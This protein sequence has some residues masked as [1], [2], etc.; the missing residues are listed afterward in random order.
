MGPQSALRRF[1]GDESG[2]GI[3]FA[4]ATLLVLVGFL[5]FV[6]N[7]GRLLDRRT[8]M[9]IAADA[10][11]YSG[12]MVE[13]D[14][15]S[16]IAY[17]NSAMSQVYYNSLKYAVDVNEAAVAAELERRMNYPSYEPGAVAWPAYQTV[18]S[19]ASAGLQQA[20]Q[21]MVQLSQ[22]ENAIAIV[23]PRLAEE[24]MYVVAARAGGERMSVYPSFRMF[25]AHDSLIEFEITRLTV[26]QQGWQVRNRLTNDTLTLTLVGGN[27]WDFQWT[28]N[29]I[30]TREVK[31][32]QNS[33]TSWQIQFYQ[34]P[35]SLKQEVNI[36]DD[37]NLGWVISGSAPNPG[38][39]PPTPMQPITFT[40]VDMDGEGFNEGVRITQGG[41]SQVLMRGAD[42]NM[43]AW[44]GSSYVPM[45][46]NQTTVGGVNVQ[47]NV[48][49][50]IHFPGAT[51][52]IG[53]PTTVDI[54]GAHIVLN[55]PPTI[56]TGFGPVGISISG[57][58]PNQ[59]NI[60]VG[61][62]SLMPGGSDGRWIPHYDAREEM[63][64]RNQLISNVYGNPNVWWYNYERYGAL[65]AHDTT[66]RLTQHAFM[67]NNYSPDSSATGA[68]AWPTWACTANNATPWFNTD[69]GYAQPQ[70]FI[71]GNL[72]S[73]WQPQFPAVPGQ[74][75]GDFDVPDNNGICHLLP[76]N[77]GQGPGA[78]YPPPGA[79]Y[80]TSPLNST[81]G[82]P[83]CN[84]T[85]RLNG[86][87][88]NGICTCPWCHG[89]DNS[90]NGNSRYSN[91]R[92]SL[93]TLGSS[94]LFP[95]GVRRDP[96]TF[97]SGIDYLTAPMFLPTN[98]G[99]PNPMNGGQL[100]AALRPLVATKYFF[101]SGV[102]IGVWKEPITTM[103]FP[104][105]NPWLHAPNT[106]YVPGTNVQPAW[107][108]VAI[109]GARVGLTTIKGGMP[110][111]GLALPSTNGNGTYLCQFADPSDRDNWCQSSLQNLYYA[112]VQA[113]LY[114]SK[115]QVDDFD[116]DPNLLPEGAPVVENGLSY[117][118]NAILTANRDSHNDWLDRFNGQADPRVSQAL[119]NMQDRQLQTFDY[120]QRQDLTQDQAGQNSTYLKQVFEH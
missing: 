120:G 30:E 31:I 5:A 81:M 48:T 52:H 29:G 41:Y 66:G 28:N 119:R 9:Q 78:T 105:D 55:N 97:P 87:P 14:A 43:Y 102:N 67:G 53:Q 88:A 60:S 117:L 8:K 96:N 91:I 19:T 15:V 2:Q 109:A 116:L 56:S 21:W 98:T 86:N 75:G 83:A 113:T 69:P 18:Y 59:F 85:G 72:A 90:P 46:S 42:G 63:W 26:P 24:E 101:Q 93:A 3:I 77:Q 103:L 13:A 92:V 71:P 74:A 45:T 35:G 40:P 62:F 54:G 108:N 10:A 32:T 39:G 95:A 16:A 110:P 47:V 65:L 27:V 7:I 51:A 23:A 20:K 100:G 99:Y 80:Q 111:G 68:G 89:C 6:F 1:C 44:N 61:G 107:G 11:A 70:E 73:N 50:V 25:P 33:P 94:P 34:P 114:A 112:D 118:L 22:L 4:A 82:C 38:G 79:Y 36:V 84:G 104:S 57:F 76:S 58:N 12:A 49:N 115:N 17:I 64:W 106:H 37:P